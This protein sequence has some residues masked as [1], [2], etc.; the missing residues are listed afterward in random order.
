MLRIIPYSLC[1]AA[2]GF[3]AV[4]AVFCFFVLDPRAFVTSDGEKL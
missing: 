3:C 4:L 2:F 1:A